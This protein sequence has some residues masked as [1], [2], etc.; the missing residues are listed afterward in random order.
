MTEHVERVRVANANPFM[1]TDRH[2]GILYEFPPHSTTVVPT[3]V[4]QHIFGYPGDTQDMRVYMA[5]R[6]GWNRP[7]HYK[8]D[9]DGTLPWERMTRNI[10]LTVEHYEMR[11]ILA[12]GAPIPAEQAGEAPDMLSINSDP[13]APRR[14]IVSRRRAKSGKRKVR[15]RQLA[16]ASGPLTAPA[17]EPL[18]TDGNE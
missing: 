2:D 17:A 5:R 4:A 7:E 15:A 13:P 18:V 8:P 10:R 14:A 3:E 12:P 16:T 1:I 9:D 11:R 6:F